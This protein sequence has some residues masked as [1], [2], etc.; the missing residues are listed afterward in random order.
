MLPPM[1]SAGCHYVCRMVI[2]IVFTY[3]KLGGIVDS[4]MPL[5]AL[6]AQ[7]PPKLAPS[8]ARR[9]LVG[10][11]AYSWITSLVSLV[12][13]SLWG[14]YWCSVTQPQLVVRFMTV[15]SNKEIN[16]AVPIGCYLFSV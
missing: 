14:W 8:R 7:V 11:D 5:S 2:L 10:L 15:R 1:H 12:R 13:L 4:T 16:R 9:I 6:V 3:T